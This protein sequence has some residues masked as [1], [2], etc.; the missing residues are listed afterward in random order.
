MKIY[1]LKVNKSQSHV[2]KSDTFLASVA[3]GAGRQ[4]G[5]RSDAASLLK[6]AL[7][8]RYDD[9]KVVEN[10]RGSIWHVADLKA[11]HRLRLL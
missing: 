1:I 6:L 11:L 3:R 5:R 2:N 10:K 8:T 9:V 4:P 7:A